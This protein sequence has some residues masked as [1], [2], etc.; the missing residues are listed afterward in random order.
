MSVLMEMSLMNWVFKCPVKLI[1]AINFMVRR[2]SMISK[3]CLRILK[4]D[5]KLNF[6]CLAYP[7]KMQNGFYRV[8]FLHFSY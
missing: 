6:G 1:Y 4:T 7:T 5:K 8:V 2:D 3:F